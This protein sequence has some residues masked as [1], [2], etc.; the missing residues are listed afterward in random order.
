[1]KKSHSQLAD[2]KNLFRRLPPLSVTRLD[3]RH[4]LSGE[5]TEAPEAPI[6]Y[7]KID[8]TIPSCAFGF[9]LGLWTGGAIGILFLKVTQPTYQEHICTVMTLWT[10]P[11]AV[12][13]G[14]I[15]SNL[16]SAYY[17]HETPA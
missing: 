10:L 17:E 12:A 16:G 5:P 11:A 2:K 8:Y 7:A 1:M 14:V 3:N 6:S 9:T 13:G 15:G 4:L